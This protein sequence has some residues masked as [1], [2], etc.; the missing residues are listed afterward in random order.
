M[1]ESPWNVKR[2]TPPGAK[3]FTP[4]GAQ[5]RHIPH[6]SPPQAA[7]ARPRA[8]RKAGRQI[9]AQRPAA[10]AAPQPEAG[11]RSQSRK[12]RKGGFPAA[13]AGMLGILAI[14]LA[15]LSISLIRQTSRLQ[16]LEAEREAIRRQQASKV[17]N[18]L[19]HRDQSGYQ[20]LIDSYSAEYQINPAFVAAVIKC[21]SNF[22]PRAISY[23]D[24]R[25]LMQI[26]PDTG[27]WL[28]G[29]LGTANYS[30]DKLFD[31]QLNIQY[32]AYYLSYLSNHFG[33]QPV[34]VAAAYHAGLNNVK[35][36]AL[37]Y[38]RDKKTLGLEELPMSD[39]RD[40]VRKVMDAYAIYYEQDQMEKGAVPGAVPDAALA[41]GHSCG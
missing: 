31:P 35:L 39:T 7:P 19:R 22:Q 32:G 10:Q 29:R 20:K 12:A 11:R 14:V 37:K 3:P 15:V 8:R 36:W 1:S 4:E 6:R 30:I 18:H 28:S 16:A 5:V 24:A 23:A 41:S 21:E 2:K 9:F 38:A 17:E 13:A 25:G 26:M 33:G 34:M 40:Y 27:V